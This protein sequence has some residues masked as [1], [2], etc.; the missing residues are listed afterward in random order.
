[1]LQLHKRILIRSIPRPNA[2]QGKSLFHPQS[3]QEVRGYKH[4][5]GSTPTTQCIL[6][7]CQTLSNKSWFKQIGKKIQKT[8]TEFHM[9]QRKNT[10]KWTAYRYWIGQ[11]HKGT[12]AGRT[13]GVKL[14]NKKWQNNLK[15][16]LLGI[17]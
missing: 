2:L 8:F 4:S 11:Y 6:F 9:Y 3:N 1:M 12:P 17:A 13:S 16:S 7:H 14:V 15:L 5:A 10:Q